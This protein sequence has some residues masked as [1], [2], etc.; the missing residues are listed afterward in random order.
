MTRRAGT[1]A[2]RTPEGGR[3][4]LRPTWLRPALWAALVAAGLLGLAL[5][6]AL[7]V[8]PPARVVET[9]A[10]ARYPDVQP[11]AL[12]V[13]LERARAALSEGVASDAAWTWASAWEAGE[14]RAWRST[15]ERD[16]Q[17]YEVRVESNGDGGALVFVRAEHA[18]LGVDWGRRARS[19]EA[20]LDATSRNVSRGST[21]RSSVQGTPVAR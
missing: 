19:I 15:L 5:G 18:G 11:L 1:G 2:A 8:W 21:G 4:R 12:S 17:P 3:R 13:S 10:T 14:G 6:A 20:L 16:G 7:R 9:G